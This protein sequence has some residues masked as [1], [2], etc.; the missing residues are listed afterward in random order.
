MRTRS[1][2][3]LLAK[4]GGVAVKQEH[5]PE[6]GKTAAPLPRVVKYAPSKPASLLPQAKTKIE[7][8]SR[9]PDNWR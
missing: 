4:A 3:A 1:L 8:P 9:S 6:V 5:K 7:Q 2:P